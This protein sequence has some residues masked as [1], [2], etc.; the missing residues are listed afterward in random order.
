MSR[1]LIAYASSY[2]Q[3][4]K[5]AKALAASLRRRGHV[6]EL[7]DAFAGT[8]PPVEDYDA[9]VLGSRVELGLHAHAIAEY[10]TVNREA[11]D[12]VPSFFF[13]VSMAAASATSADPEG[14]LEKL[15]ATTHWRPRAAIAIAGGL[16]YRKYSWI[17]RWIMKLISARAGH[18]TDTSRDHDYTDWVQVEQ[19][20]DQIASALPAQPTEP[21]PQPPAGARA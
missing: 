9:V 3:T 17:L 14:Y 16:P 6:I 21:A 11:L 13:S 15:F 5:I 1:I 8:P 2:G 4:H 7:A 19:F 12:E 20:A 18:A 10:A